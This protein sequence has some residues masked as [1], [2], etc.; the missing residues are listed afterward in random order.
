MATDLA[1]WRLGNREQV[2]LGKRQQVA[3]G[4]REQ[5]A[6]IAITLCTIWQ[7][8]GAKIALYDDD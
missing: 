8:S 4:K 1:R 6:K 2:A 7:A 5:L 3:L